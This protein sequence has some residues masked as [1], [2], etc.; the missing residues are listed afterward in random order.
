VALRDAS[1]RELGLQKWKDQRL[2]VLKRDG[3]I[4][5]YCGQEANQVDHVIS[6]KDGGSHDLENLV[7]CCAPCNSKKGALN[8][9]VFLGKSSTPPV[10]SS[11]PSPMQSE[12]MLDSPFKTRPSPSQ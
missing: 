6:R 2:R 7:A 3:Y 9:G 5:A 10:F 11:H 12:T 8:E 4:C 1:H